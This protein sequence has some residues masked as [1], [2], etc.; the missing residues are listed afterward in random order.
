MENTRLLHKDVWMPEWVKSK[1]KFLMSK[2]TNLFISY[3]LMNERFDNPNRSHDISATDVLRIA[4]TLNAKPVEPF[5]VEL[6]YD[7]FLK[8]WMITKYV[9]RLPYTSTQDVSIAIRNRK[10]VT[11]WLNS[12]TDN[13][14]TLDTSKYDDNL[15]I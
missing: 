5:E 10:I 11:V 4:N 13:H 3:H 2:R 6:E 15:N 12:T 1:S 8:K 7:Y 14:K 9:V